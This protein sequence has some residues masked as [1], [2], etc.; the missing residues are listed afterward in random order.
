[1][2]AEV[3]K[4][5]TSTAVNIAMA[6]KALADGNTALFARLTK[7]RSLEQTRR[8]QEI[9]SERGSVSDNSTS[10]YVKELVASRL[11]TLGKGYLD[12]MKPSLL[13]Y[14]LHPE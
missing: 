6:E 3:S 7:T 10:K 14:E 13:C 2:G 4:D 8:G 5:V 12:N 1:M 9:V 11:E